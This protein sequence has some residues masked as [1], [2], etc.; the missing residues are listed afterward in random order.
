METYPASDHNP[1]NNRNK[2]SISDPSLPLKGHQIGKQSGKKR[3]RCTDGLVEGDGE[4]AEGDIAADHRATENEAESRNF[5]ELGPRL[6]HLERHNLEQNN[7]EV[8]ENGA[9]RHVAHCKEDWESESII[10]E[11]KLVEEK[12]ANIRRIPEDH[13]RNYEKGLVI[14][15]HFYKIF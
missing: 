12:N 4:V 5:E 8:A 2:S 10:G 11:Q 6:E 14:G 1:S 3:S 15:G 7:G 9:R 13:K